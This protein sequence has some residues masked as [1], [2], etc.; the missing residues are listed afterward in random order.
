MIDIEAY[1]Y[2]QV[3]NALISAYQNIDVAN[4]Y[5]ENPDA[6]PHVCI[7]M[8]DNT[9]SARYMTAQDRE[10]ATEQT[11]T[12]NIFTVSETPKSDA[13]AIAS[14]VDDTLTALGFRRSMY[15]RTPNVDRNIYRLTLRYTGMISKGYDGQS[16]HYNITAR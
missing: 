4:E 2:T 7:E 16:R 11:F 1:V 5:T 8:S 13:K 14:T 12:V 10:F 6:F 15:L 9:V 3:R